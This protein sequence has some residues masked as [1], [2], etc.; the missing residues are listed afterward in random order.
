M[1]IY[2]RCSIAGG[3]GGGG[4]A[5]IQ[6][7]WPIHRIPESVELFMHVISVAMTKLVRNGHVHPRG[8]KEIKQVN[9]LAGRTKCVLLRQRGDLS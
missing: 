6:L 4:V 3:G 1:L 5:V 2:G 8:R 9:R 7:S